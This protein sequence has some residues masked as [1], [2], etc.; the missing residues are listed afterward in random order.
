MTCTFEPVSEILSAENTRVRPTY[1][2][3]S[4]HIEDCEEAIFVKCVALTPTPWP[5]SCCAF[6]DS[7]PLKSGS[8]TSSTIEGISS[9]V[10][11][12]AIQPINAQGKG[13]A[14]HKSTPIVKAVIFFLAAVFI[15]Q[16]S[17]A[18][19]KPEIFVQLGH[20]GKVKSVTFSP[21]GRYAL[22]GSE[23]HTLKLWEVSTGKEI[24][25]FRGLSQ[26]VY[27]VAFSPNGK[28][29]LSGSG[30]HEREPALILWNVSTG[31]EIRRFEGHSHA[32]TSVC[33]STDGQYILSGGGSGF[34]NKDATIKLWDVSSGKLIRTF[35]GHT[36]PVTAVAFSPDGQQALSASEDYSLKLWEISTGREIRTFKDAQTNILS[37]SP[38]G[39]YVLT[40][41]FKKLDLFE[42]STGKK[43]KTFTGHADYIES[44]SFAPD[45]SY[46][47][48][49][50]RA[51]H[52][53]L[54]NIS[55]GLEIRKL[56]GHMGWVN[57]LTFSP[58]GRC[59]LSGSSDRTLKLW[60]VKTGREVRTY[61]GNVSSSRVVAFSPDGR[62]I[63][64][65]SGM[66]LNLWDT[67]TGNAVRT[68]KGHADI[69][70]DVAFLPD[71]RHVLS[72]SG[73]YEGKKDNTLRLW[74]TT[75][76]KTVRS[77]I[78]HLKAVYGVAV[79]PDG[80]YALSTGGDNTIGLWEIFTGRKIR[81]FSGLPSCLTFS[82]DGRNAL[83]VHPLPVKNSFMNDHILKKWD[84]T[85]GRKISSY[86]LSYNDMGYGITF[87]SDTKYLLTNKWEV[88]ETSTGRKVQ[89]ISGGNYG[90]AH[91]AA[92]SPDNRYILLGH[93]SNIM[94]LWDVTSGKKMREFRGHSGTVF[95]VAF[96]PDGRYALSG[97]SDGTVRIWDIPTE[98]EIVQMVRFTDG[99]WIA[100]IPEGYYVSSVSGDKHMNV[101]IGN[102]IYGIDQY[103]STFYRPQVVEAALKTGD[104]HKAIVEALGTVKEKPTLATIKKIEP[105]FVVIK[106]PEEGK[107]IDSA[108]TDVAVY[109]EDRNQTIKSIGVYVNGRMVSS[110]ESRGI[111][112]TSKTGRI[113]IPQG[114]KGVDVKI[115]V[116]LEKGENLVE[117]VASNGFSERRKSVRIYFE[118][119]SASQGELILPSLWI[120]AIGVNGYED[121]NLP[122]LS[123]AAADAGGV[124]D[125]LKGQKGKLFREINSL[126][127]NDIS[128]LKPTYE[129]IADNLNYLSRAGHND[130]VILFIAGHGINDDRGDFYFLPSDAVILPDGVIKRSR[131]IS[132]RDLK[133]VLDLPSKKIIFADTCHSE[134]ISGKKTR[135]V[136]NDRFVKELQQAN[137]VIFT[138]SRGRE[139]SQESDKWGHGAFTYALIEGIKGKANLIKDSRISMKELDTFVSETVPKLTNGAQHPITNTPDGYVNFPVALV[140]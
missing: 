39:Q 45:G 35:Y 80:R 69:I 126:I 27:S 23:D 56:S 61:A 92:F 10:L 124:V 18:A 105:P 38:D 116:T 111:A 101:R 65:A 26:Y 108:S 19:D 99:E 128:T 138:S 1:L 121:K 14:M 129:N 130:V 32:V 76:G 24:R 28:Y 6:D 134:G 140:E 79:S 103:R 113:V 88:W 91:S 97:S 31:E 87:S 43:I 22:S 21:D 136:N 119:S 34:K 139:L 123:Y 102:N 109:A 137:A 51:G 114:G 135:A 64:A 82:N 58:D 42:V 75:T 93:E 29:I 57:A 11:G 63:I 7:S 66:D 71:G 4:L 48:S 47:V 132:W 127:I 52:I 37:L 2:T 62:S 33:F 107:R 96:S 112:I 106:S 86:P 104:T 5:S 20:A 118:E 49:G 98:R 133:A 120:L 16:S 83:S 12:N 125:V 36:K 46:A 122:P 50:D 41:H 115:P 85:S 44:V 17:T 81:T 90:F 9:E 94:T 67:F 110:G 117:V 70:N 55:S 131:A 77:F 13:I 40:E 25:T 84:T 54:W 8:S 53:I 72:T 89:K 60:D 3:R 74:D 78:G 15:P 100:M 68:L 73:S 95:S 59:V 30:F